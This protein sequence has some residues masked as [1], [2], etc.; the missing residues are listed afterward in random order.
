MTT[1][2]T[3][4]RMAI[5][6]TY[7]ACSALG[8][9]QQLPRSLF[10]HTPSRTTTIS[11]LKTT[12]QIT[13]FVFL[14][15]QSPCCIYLPPTLEN[16]L[17]QTQ[18]ETST[19]W[20][21]SIFLPVLVFHPICFMENKDLFLF[22]NYSTIDVSCLFWRLFTACNTPVGFAVTSMIWGMLNMEMESNSL[23]TRFSKA[24]T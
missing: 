5:H 20:L 13:P 7:F 12:S 22:C 15:S 24:P 16:H 18:I 14:F 8:L 1:P 23:I 4:H 21:L 10:R 9:S 17:V 19:H 11:V 6:I 3:V 2:R